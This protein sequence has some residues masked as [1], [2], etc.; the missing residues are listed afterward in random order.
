MPVSLPKTEGFE[1]CLLWVSPLTFSSVL[2]YHASMLPPERTVR[3]CLT[4]LLIE[5]RL[6]SY[7]L[8]QLLDIPERQVEDHL[9]HIVK[10]L[11]RDQ[12]RRFVLDPSVCSDCGFVF[13]DRTKLTRPSRCPTCRSEAVTALRYGIDAIP[14]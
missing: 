11:A 8:A 14:R 3:Q 12:S 5:T 7:Q 2:P 4:E 1:K 13:R 10:S 6:S 9:P